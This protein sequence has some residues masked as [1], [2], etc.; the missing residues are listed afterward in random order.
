[1]TVSREGKVAVVTGSGR[2]IGQ[3]MA[4]HMAKAGARGV[5]NDLGVSLSG[6]AEE[7][8][9]AQETI[10]IIKNNG[11]EAVADPMGA[12]RIVQTALD[13]FERIDVVST[14]LAFWATGCFIKCRPTTGLRLSTR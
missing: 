14:M 6:A 9:P 10:S 3:A 8:D 7:V 11:G 12:R 2:G 4:V 1:M 5:L 13:S